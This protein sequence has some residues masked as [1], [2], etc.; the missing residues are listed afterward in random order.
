MKI[1]VPS[2]APS[3]KEVRK[4]YVTFTIDAG[5]HTWQNEGKKEKL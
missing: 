5:T 2:A 4:Y 3:G 1:Y